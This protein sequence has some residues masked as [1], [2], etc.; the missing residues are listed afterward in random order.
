[1]PHGG[2]ILD[3]V[4]RAC[5]ERLSVGAM[6][7]LR[8]GDNYAEERRSPGSTAMGSRFQPLIAVIDMVDNAGLAT[9]GP[10]FP[11]L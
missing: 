5:A 6:C 1:V 2:A 10:P 11:A 9:S 3:C 4:V 7:V 8:A